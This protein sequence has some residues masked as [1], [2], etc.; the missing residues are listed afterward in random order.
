MPRPAPLHRT[1]T[2]PAF[3]PV[4]PPQA[5]PT[6]AAR[7][8]SAP[9][10][11]ALTN[12]AFRPASWSRGIATGVCAGARI[13]LGPTGVVPCLLTTASTA[14][15]ARPAV[16][17][18]VAWSQKTSF[19]RHAAPLL[20]PHAG[21]AVV[22]TG[23]LLAA[24]AL[25]VAQL[26]RQRFGAA[27]NGASAFVAA[28]ALQVA[29]GLAVAPCLAT[30]MA[31][32][33]PAGSLVLAGALALTCMLAAQ[34]ALGR[35]PSPMGCAAL[36]GACLLIGP[37][38]W[39]VACGMVPQVAVAQSVALWALWLTAAAATAAA[40][41]K[42]VHDAPTPFFDRGVLGPQ[43]LRP[44]RF[45]RPEAANAAANP[46]RL[47]PTIFDVDAGM[48]QLVARL[49]PELPRDPSAPFLGFRGQPVCHL[50]GPAGGGKTRSTLGLA[51]ELGAHYRATDANELEADRLGDLPV[52]A[53]NACLLLLSADAYGRKER[54]PVVLL[55]D[56]V[57]ALLPSP[58]GVQ[59]QA[60][61]NKALGYSLFV[62]T[63]RLLQ[64]N[65]SYVV[66][67]TATNRYDTY[68]QMLQLL[69][70]NG[71]VYLG[72]P[73][74]QSK[75]KVLAAGLRDTSEALRHDYGVSWAPNFD[76]QEAE[77][78]QLLARCEAQGALSLRSMANLAHVGLEAGVGEAAR[79]GRAR[80]AL[81]DA[82]EALVRR[83]F[84]A[85]H[86]EL[87]AR[88]EERPRE[89]APDA[90]P[91]NGGPTST[92]ASPKTSRK[93]APNASVATPN[94]DH[95]TSAKQKAA[96]ARRTRRA[97]AQA[98]VNLDR[99]LQQTGLRD[100][101]MVQVFQ[102]IAENLGR[103]YPKPENAVRFAELEL[104][105]AN[106]FYL[107]LLHFLRGATTEAPA[108]LHHQ[109]YVPSGNNAAWLP[110]AGALLRAG[111]RAARARLRANAVLKRLPSKEQR[112]PATAPAL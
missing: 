47:R 10:A 8:N 100:T 4:L 91:G 102:T 44:Y 46:A 103:E 31:L 78:D 25:A 24:T 69:G 80:A 40:V 52:A 3:V 12:R 105:L 106:V 53:I 43:A 89:E 55:V 73:N 98:Q 58:D 38:G 18:V 45:E 34:R 20:G 9:D 93:S 74:A 77:V 22:V 50:H 94:V 36:L 61:I 32:M 110:S 7:P 63:L 37:P 87:D 70:Q 86:E 111:L 75:R 99:L 11:A 65:G 54:R 71:G 79:Q 92:K 90:K 85:M 83:A 26:T 76:A 81:A 41:H 27:P 15:L 72:A 59:D 19:L 67:I 60:R 56:E 13:A 84:A 30:G 14:V 49:Q 96:D 42:L 2:L 23:L 16:A 108:P 21:A 17:S 51:R 62:H 33:G 107:S 28:H 97:D 35:T 104:R 1:T 64:R 66:L 6:S 57:D 82:Q 95:S 39:S 112:A 88:D 109:V 5:P 48:W 29:L 101:S 68:E